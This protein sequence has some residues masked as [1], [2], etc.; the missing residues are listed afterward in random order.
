MVGAWRGGEW[1]SGVRGRCCEAAERGGAELG[2]A[3]QIAQDRESA[4]EDDVPA[5][6]NA[7]TDAGGA[8]ILVIRL[9]C[10]YGA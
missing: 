10:F 4:N 2:R 8:D 1:G 6:T 9:V 7:T 3:Q 5:L